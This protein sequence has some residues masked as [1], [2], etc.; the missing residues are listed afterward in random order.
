MTGRGHELVLSD[1][2]LDVRAR[3]RLARRGNIPRRR[4]TPISA[5]WSLHDVTEAGN[6]ECEGDYSSGCT[7]SMNPLSPTDCGQGVLDLQR[8]CRLRRPERGGHAERDRRFQALALIDG[9][10]SGNADHR[11]MH[12]THDRGHGESTY[13]G[14][15]T[16][17]LRCEGRLLLRLRQ[18]C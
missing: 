10:S 18:G 1:H 2:C 4:F 14:R 7:G 5:Q 11:S 8:G 6:G 16:R 13:A 9:G 15:S 3:G 12:R 17:M